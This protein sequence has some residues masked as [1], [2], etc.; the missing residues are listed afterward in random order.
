MYIDMLSIIDFI[1]GKKILIIIAN[2]NKNNSAT[3]NFLNLI[4]F[5]IVYINTPP[6][7]KYL[8]YNNIIH[9]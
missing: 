1:E 2:R 6:K 8:Q 7:T 3:S 9:L 4:S 5:N